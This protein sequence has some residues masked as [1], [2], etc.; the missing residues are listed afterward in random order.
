MSRARNR[1]SQNT[2]AEELYAVIAIGAL[3]AAAGAASGHRSISAHPS[4]TWSHR[5]MNPVVLIARPRREKRH[6]GQR[7]PPSSL[8]AE[9]V[10]ARHP[11]HCRSP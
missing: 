2:M 1:M 10:T 5:P 9:L 4:T 6:R 11:G 8:A 7:P 3:I